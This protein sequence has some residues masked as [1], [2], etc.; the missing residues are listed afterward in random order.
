MKATEDFLE[1]VVKAHVLTVTKQLQETLT[2]VQGCTDLA[3][4]L[5]TRFIMM[6]VP[7]IPKLLAELNSENSIQETEENTEDPAQEDSTPEANDLV[8]SYAV[9][10]LTIGLLWYGF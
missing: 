2:N 6:S 9:D 1:L 8:Y 3:K 10:I 4:M 5:V 7:D